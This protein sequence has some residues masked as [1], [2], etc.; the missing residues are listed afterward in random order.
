MNVATFYWRDLLALDPTIDTRADMY[1]TDLHEMVD[2]E[3]MN[4]TDANSMAAAMCSHIVSALLHRLALKDLKVDANNL[5]INNPS[6][7]IIEATPMSGALSPT[8]IANIETSLYYELMPIVTRNN[9]TLVKLTFTADILTGIRVDIS[10]N[11]LPVTPYTRPAFAD[12]T[13]APVISPHTTT[14]LQTGMAEI[15]GMTDMSN[16]LRRAVDISNP[17]PEYASTDV[18]LPTGHIY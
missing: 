12:S 4:N 13:T 17:H 5:D 15:L 16:K 3:Y 7:V 11:G 1:T 9:S 18:I 8:L 14:E 10:V 2:S 6:V